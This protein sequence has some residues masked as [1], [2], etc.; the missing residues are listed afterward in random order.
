MT[1]IRA[2]LDRDFGGDIIEPGAA[3]YESASRSV[4]AVGQPGRMCCG[5]S[6]VGDVQAAVRFAASA[7]LRAVRARR[8][9]RLPGLRHQRRRRRD[10]PQQARER[11]DHRRGAPPRADRR[12]RH[13]GSGRGRPG[14][15]RPGDLLGRHQERRRR[16]ADLDRRH[17]LEGQEVRP[18]PGQP[19]RAPRWSPPTERSCRRARRRTRSCSGRFAAAA[20]TSGSSPPSSSRHTR[21]PTSSSARSRSRQRRRPRVLQG[22]ADYLRTAPEELTST[23]DFANPF[24]GGPEAPVEIHVAF[25]GDDPELAAAGHRPDPPARHG[26]RRRRRAE[27][28]RGHARGGHD[29]AARHPVRRPAARSSTR[30]RSPEVLQILAEVG[31]SERSPFIAVRSVGGAVSRVPDDATAYAHRRRS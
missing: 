26:A 16:R 8:R 7:G 23:V 6:S 17:R 19:G 9:P 4:L 21:R 12:R 11:G 18:G 27:A 15:A 20:A 13:L 30:T 25:D 29:P 22:W 1:S 28:V 5:P 31:A 24:R 2:D 14:P 10:R 3:E